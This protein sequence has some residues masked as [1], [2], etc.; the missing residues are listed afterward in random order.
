MISP[1]ASIEFDC[2]GG[3]AGV[4][5]A[6]ARDGDVPSPRACRDGRAFLLDVHDRLSRF[7]R[8]SEL[9][10]LNADRRASVPASPLMLAFAEGVGWAGELSGG[11]VDATRLEPLERLGYDASWAESSGLSLDETLAQAPAPRPA[12]PHPAREWS[13]V[14]AD[15]TRACVVRPHGVGL[16][17]GGIAKGLAADLLAARL[18]ARVSY[19]VECAGDLRVGGTEGVPR[20][21]RVDDPFGRGVI[22]TLT[23]AD[24]GVATSGIGRRSWRRPDGSAAHHLLD[25]STGRP[26]FTGIVQATAL[27]PTALHAEVLAKTALL[28][29]P[30]AAAETLEWGGV[31]VHDDRTV[32]VVSASRPAEEAAR[33]VAR[34]RRGSMTDPSTH[35]FWITSRAAGFTALLAASASVAVGIASAPNAPFRLGSRRD[36]RPL[37]EALALITLA[38]IAV[39]GVVLLGDSFLR[40]G[41]TGILVPFAGGYRPFWT[42]LGIIGAYGLAA[43]GLTYYMRARIGPER[44]RIAH[45]FTVVFWLAA[46]VHSFGAGTDAWQPWFLLVSAL[47]IG[48]AVGMTLAA[49]AASGSARRAEREIR[50]P[51]LDSQ[52]GFME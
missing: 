1:E 24:A 49:I 18:A 45:R 50:L 11:L 17:S 33:R 10:R 36:L 14:E 6:P 44:W 39:H 27:A 12:S 13:L 22:H 32:E 16:D 41:L 19:A 2:F 7:L 4:R 42:G 52:R 21:V 9:S 28:R 35:L 51:T 43:L 3:R 26:A 30:G 29:G 20:E 34:P 38:A 15:R 31:L 25:P 46:V 40:P 23:L 47:V 37:H 48:P 5:A 8:G